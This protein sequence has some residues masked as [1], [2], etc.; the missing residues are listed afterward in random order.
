LPLP[1]PSREVWNPNVKDVLVCLEGSPSTE[2]ATR[3][4]WRSRA[5]QN[6]HLIG[7]AIVDEARIRAGAA[8]GI[9]GASFKRERD[10][11]LMAEAA[12]TRVNGAGCSTSAAAAQVWPRPADRGQTA[13]AASLREMQ[14]LR[15]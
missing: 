4:A 10:D 7:L 3:V 9:G 11:A 12:D 6:A 8:T 13:A 5:G 15:F 2:A 1:L 14:T